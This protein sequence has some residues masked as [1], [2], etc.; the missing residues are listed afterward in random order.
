[1]EHNLLVEILRLV[2]DSH[3]ARGSFQ[4]GFPATIPVS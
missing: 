4:N 3:C 1:M 2:S